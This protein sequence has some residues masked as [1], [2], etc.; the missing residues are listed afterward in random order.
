M[1]TR[2]YRKTI[3][4]YWQYNNVHHHGSCTRGSHLQRAPSQS[5]LRRSRCVWTLLGLQ[6]ATVIQK[7]FPD[8]MISIQPAFR[9]CRALTGHW[10]TTPIYVSNRSTR[11]A[12][13]S[14][15][16]G[17]RIDIR[18]VLATSPPIIMS[19]RSSPRLISPPCTRARA[20]F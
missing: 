4:T 8:G 16:H 18:A 7:I 1:S 20:R 12:Q 10:L 6:I 13:A 5:H 2:L 3:L 9:G 19:T 14:E 11:K 15:A 17:S